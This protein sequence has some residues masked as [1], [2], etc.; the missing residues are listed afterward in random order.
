[1]AEGK[2]ER[3]EKGTRRGKKGEKENISSI[4]L[5]PFFPGLF[6]NVEISFFLTQNRWRPAFPECKC[7]LYF[8]KSAFSGLITKPPFKDFGAFQKSKAQEIF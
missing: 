1:M 2:W 7:H 3:E 4:T 6:A 5:L 8:S